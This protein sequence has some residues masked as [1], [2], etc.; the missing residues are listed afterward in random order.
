MSDSFVTPWT[1][2]CSSVHV[3]S[4]TQEYWSGLPFPSPGDLPYPNIEPMSPAL[5]GGFF[6]IEPP[7]KPFIFLV[8]LKVSVAQ[9]CPTV[10]DPMD[11]SLPGSSV[12]GIFQARIL[13]WVAISFSGGSSQWR[14]ELNLGLQHF[15]QAL[16]HLSHQGSSSNTK[17]VNICP[18]LVLEPIICP[19]E[20]FYYFTSS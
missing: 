17:Y 11:C 3:I 2:A 5:A 20:S 14:G 18:P 4:Q 7:G 8:T 6:T 12:H 13:E 15:R 1:V 16:Y 19:Q 10:C 9:S